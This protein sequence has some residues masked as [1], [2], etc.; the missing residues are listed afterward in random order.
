MSS[1]QRTSPYARIVR[2]KGDP[3]KAQEAMK[4]W[5]EEVLPL[6][7]KQFGFG[8]VVMLGDRKTGDGLSVSYW[9]SEK[10]MKDARG[11]V[12]PAADK[13]ME[14]TGG[15]IVDEDE[16]EVAVLERFK[17]TQQG[18]WVRLTTAP[19]DPARTSEAID[20]FKDMVVP[21]LKQQPGVRTAVFFVNRSAGKAFGGS[22]WDTEQDLQKS[23]AAISALRAETI[24]K[25]GGK[26]AKTE[27]FE[28]LYAEILTPVA[29][30]H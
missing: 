21:V 29:L 5:T 20:N 6:L 17:P 23:E 11:Q 18:T 19:G 2:L 12:R 28:I 3:S 15:S 26:D 25:A 14:K 24:K 8:G 13:M 30:V 10:E 27:V 7:K 16:C 4:L 22:V 1:E 9:D